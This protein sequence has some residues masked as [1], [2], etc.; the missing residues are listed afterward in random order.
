MYTELL[1][2]VEAFLK[3]AE[4]QYLEFLKDIKNVAERMRRNLGKDFIRDVY[5]R[6]TK[7]PSEFKSAPK[8]AKALEIRRRENPSDPPYSIDDIIGLTIIVYYPDQVEAVA[9]WLRKNHGLKADL[10]KDKYMR[11]D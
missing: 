4:L 6:I 11:A 9:A 2:E 10:V 3:A 1:P 5:S 7:Q 8:I